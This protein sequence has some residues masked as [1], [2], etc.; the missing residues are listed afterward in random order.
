VNDNRKHSEKVPPEQGAEGTQTVMSHFWIFEAR[1]LV[2]IG[3]GFEV[4]L[5]SA[6]QTIP[7]D[8]IQ[9]IGVT[10]AANFT[11]G[12]VNSL[13]D[14]NGVPVHTSQGVVDFVRPSGGGP[15]VGGP[16]TTNDWLLDRRL[17]CRTFQ[18]RSRYGGTLI[19]I[20]RNPQL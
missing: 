11:F 13:L 3:K 9:E 17:I 18:H 15:G 6:A 8:L 5:N 16:L 7:F 10:P 2:G 14:A 1:S 19:A 4:R 20:P 12:F